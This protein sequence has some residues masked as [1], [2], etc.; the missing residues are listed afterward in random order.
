VRVPETWGWPVGIGLSAEFGYQ[1]RAFS[2]DRWTLELRPIVDKQ[3]GPWYVSFNPSL[4]RSL[5]GENSSREFGFSPSVKIGYDLTSKIST[6]VEYYGALGPITG[7]D[8]PKDQQHQLFPVVDL[9]LG[10]QWEF[11]FGVGFGLTRSTDRFLVKLIF[12]YRF[13]WKRLLARP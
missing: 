10:P 9:N 13:D 3:I 8:R 11:N 4:E 7:F 1:R 6:G 2:T 5:K 12:G